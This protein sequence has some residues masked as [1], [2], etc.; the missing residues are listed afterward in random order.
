MESKKLRF[1]DLG[2]PVVVQVIEAKNPSL[3]RF[4]YKVGDSWEVNVWESSDLCGM[5]YHNFH[6][7]IAMFQSNGEAFYKQAG[8]NFVTRTCPD[9]RPG[10]VFMIKKKE[11]GK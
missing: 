1:G 10:Y 2:C 8:K 7:D 11:Q 3:C 5:A 9:T 4:G 6:P